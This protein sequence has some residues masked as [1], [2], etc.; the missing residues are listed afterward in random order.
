MNMFACAALLSVALLPNP[1]RAT[2]AE[3]IRVTHAWLR[4]L[5]GAL[6][7]AGYAMLHNASNQPIK[8]IG[9]QSHLYA[10]VMLHLSSVAGG[11]SRM[12]MVAALQIPAQASAQLAPGGYHLMLTRPVHPVAPG[13]PVQIT[14]KFADGSTLNTTFLARP[15]N[16]MD[17]GPGNSAQRATGASATRVAADGHGATVRAH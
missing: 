16:A 10:D 9:A 4:I 1:L 6:P 7:A 8:L 15:A 12:A 5:P 13:D 3:S 11:T 14:L 2:S 17:A